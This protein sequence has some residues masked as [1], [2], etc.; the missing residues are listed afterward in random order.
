MPSLL[1]RTGLHTHRQAQKDADRVAGALADLAEA[2]EVAKLPDS[3][4]VVSNEIDVPPR[5][6]TTLARLVK[7]IHTLPN[8]E[9]ADDDQQLAGISLAKA[10]FVPLRDHA[11]VAQKN[12]FAALVATMALQVGPKQHKRGFLPFSKKV[13]TRDEAAKL[14]NTVLESIP[15]KQYSM[16]AYQASRWANSRIAPLPTGYLD[17]KSPE[18]V[19][20]LRGLLGPR[21]ATDEQAKWWR[22]DAE[23]DN[24]IEP[25]AF[26]AWQLANP[27]RLGANIV[28]MGW[29]RM[30]SAPLTTPLHGDDP[31][32]T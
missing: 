11:S 1:A 4:F 22:D 31:S 23:N 7:A 2:L 32:G 27:R 8:N 15:D 9:K 6:W 14:L 24:N 10:L 16:A 5:P 18:S 13:D 29:G 12:E 17:Q 25:E 26:Q 21:K 3:A 20:T 30:V 28:G 19:A